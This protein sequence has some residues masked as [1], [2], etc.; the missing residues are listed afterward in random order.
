MLF[1][2]F[3]SSFFFNT[4]VD[5]FFSFLEM[6]YRIRR[7]L[8][9]FLHSNQFQAIVYTFQWAYTNNRTM[10]YNLYCRFNQKGVLKQEEKKSIPRIISIMCLNV[11][12]LFNYSNFAEI[13][14]VRES[15][16]FF[17][18]IQSKLI[19]PLRYFSL[20]LLDREFYRF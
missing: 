20:R 11:L 14:K 13:M 1:S 7:C 4:D 10:D 3:F 18:I 17:Q 8:I 9:H 12:V 2:N 19:N 15:T 6:L 16:T 5:V